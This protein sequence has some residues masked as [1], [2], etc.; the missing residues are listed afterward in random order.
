MTLLLP[1]SKNLI[2]SSSHENAKFVSIFT[3]VFYRFHFPIGGPPVFQKQLKDRK[4]LAGEKVTVKCIA[5][6]LPEP[7]F[8]FRKDGQTLRSGLIKGIS[9]KYIT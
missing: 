7:Y 5:N 3:L 1:I 2:L 8:T 6:G 4:V 9:I